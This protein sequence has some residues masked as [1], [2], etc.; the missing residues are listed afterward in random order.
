LHDRYFGHHASGDIDLENKPAAALLRDAV[1]ELFGTIQ[2]LA[3][4]SKAAHA[5]SWLS[6]RNAG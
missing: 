6:A 4:D 5:V 3:W 1:E 2:I